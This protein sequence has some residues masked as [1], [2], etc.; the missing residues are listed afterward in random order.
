MKNALSLVSSARPQSSP[1][2]MAHLKELSDFQKAKATASHM[3]VMPT[4]KQLRW[5]W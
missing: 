5:A 4:S 2:T 1:V 3:V